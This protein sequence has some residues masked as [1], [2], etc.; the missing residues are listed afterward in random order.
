MYLKERRNLVEEMMTRI[1]DRMERV[2]SET[3][4]YTRNNR[5]F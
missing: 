3:N 1:I 2:T 5:P 4:L